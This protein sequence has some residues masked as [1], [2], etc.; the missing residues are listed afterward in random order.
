MPVVYRP[1]VGLLLADEPLPILEGIALIGLSFGL[2]LASV[3]RIRSQ[4]PGSRVAQV[5]WRDVSQAGYI[6]AAAAIVVLVG[7]LAEIEGLR[8]PIWLLLAVLVGLACLLLARFRWLRYAAGTG[9]LPQDDPS[10]SE[11]PRLVSTSW[12]VAFLGGGV[13]GL[14]VYGAT[15]SHAWGHP[16]HW[17]VA[18]IGVAI[19]Y[20]V[21]LVVSTPRYSVGRGSR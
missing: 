2:I 6:W 17:L 4:R 10:R 20:A 7:A 11:R 19:G 1:A 5:F 12:E 16:I 3:A 14:L 8:T 13:G 15:V 18:G 21:G 9:R